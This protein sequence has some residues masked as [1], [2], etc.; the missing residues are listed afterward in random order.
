MFFRKS[1]SVPSL[2]KLIAANC[3][4]L[5]EIE[6]PTFGSYCDS[7][8]NSRVVLI[9]DA[10]HG[11]SEFYRARA[12]MTQ[13]LITQHGFNIV[14]IEGDWPDCRT[15]DSHVRLHPG[16]V[17]MKH[18]SVFK[19]FPEWMWRNREMQRFVNWL[20]MHN[21]ELP[22]DQ[23]AGVYGLDL[24]SMGSSIQAVIKFLEKTNP[25]LA[26]DARR[27][28]L[29]LE[30]WLAAPAQ[31]GRVAMQKGYA[32]CESG[33]L[34][35][36]KQIL[37]SRLELSARQD[38][39]EGFLDAEMN[40]RL[41]RDS[42]RYY[43]SMYWAEN[44][45]WNLRDMHMFETLQRL[46]QVK[47]GKAVVWA[48]NSHLG[49]ARATGMKDRGELNLGQLCRM[50]FNSRP[51]EVAI[52]GMGTHDGEVAAAENWDEDMRIM[53]VNHSRSDSWERVMHDTGVPSFLLDLRSGYQQEEIRTACEEEK[54]ERFI[55]VIY[56]PDTERWS[57]YV[58]SSLSKQ[59][60][61]FVW[62]DTTHA[63]E[64]FEVHQP[65]EAVERGETYPF[66]L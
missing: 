9:G 60:D 19:H 31:Y 13:R 46:L 47:G 6:N 36:L 11:T 32:P 48:H 15:I 41:V 56:R 10:S 54:L 61:A 37:A 39:K 53:S 57:H 44:E 5:P 17:G 28:Y 18:M 21:G 35:M 26:K 50:I 66:G 62:F 12:A 2:S 64:A 14:A 29:C 63:V 3:V 59:F 24:Y 33:V 40:A 30:P 45:S 7:F 65:E 1:Q 51:D 52:I 23:R 55:G 25:S 34:E 22:Y 27:R 42:E 4:P 20:R 8:A 38:S 16:A 58:R 43:R 49:D